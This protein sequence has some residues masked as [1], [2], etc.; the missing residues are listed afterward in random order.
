MHFCEKKNNNEIFSVTHMT[1]SRNK[2]F[3]EDIFFI[4]TAN[5]RKKII[6]FVVLLFWILQTKVDKNF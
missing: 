4:R 3:V 6:L 1:W 2:F 5:M